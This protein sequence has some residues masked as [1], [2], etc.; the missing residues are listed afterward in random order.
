MSTPEYVGVGGSEGQEISNATQSQFRFDELRS[1]LGQSADEFRQNLPQYTKERVSSILPKYEESLESG[2]KKIASSF[3]RRGLLD[4]NVARKEI[5]QFRGKVG[6]EY[7]QQKADIGRE[8]EL[9]ARKKEQEAAATNLETQ[10]LLRQQAEDYYDLSMQNDI[11]RRRALGSFAGGV[12]YGI[13]AYYGKDAADDYYRD[14]MY[15]NQ[16]SG[17]SG[18]L[19]G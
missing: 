19:G 18:L 17:S 3:A 13:G 8:S 16:Y 6:A 1:L 10:G 9:L 2:G 15:K 7:A 12:G 4:S 11:M 14:L 5:G